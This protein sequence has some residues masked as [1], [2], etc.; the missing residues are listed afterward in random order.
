MF[1]KDP[2]KAFA[3]KLL[4]LGQE[5]EKIVTVSADSA[6]GAGMSSFLE[7]FPERHIEVGISEQSAISICAGLSEVGF[8]PVISAITPFLTM[9]AYEQVRNDIGYANMNVKMFGSG[10]GLA[11]STLGSSHAITED[12]AVMSSVPNMI[13]LNPGDST[14]VEASLEIAINYNGPVYVR[15]FRQAQ[16]EILPK[17]DHFEIGKSRTLKEGS[18]MI[19]LTTGTMI[20]PT[21]KA[22][23]LLEKKG[24]SV[25]VES[26]LTVH[27]LDR[28]QIMEI[29]KPYELVATVEEHSVI[30]GFGSLVS[31]VLIGEKRNQAVEIIGVVNNTKVGPYKELLDSHGLSPEKIAERLEKKISNI[32]EN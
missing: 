12:I 27:P 7:N 8:I 30:G 25:A 23:E 24:Y 14:E 21:L 29:T 22:A 4:S 31:N 17:Q 20:N 13:I 10:A 6:K 1:E 9:R 18:D 5:N 2:R 11:Y 3:R 26:Y 19:I 32:R 15:M 28:E 16:E